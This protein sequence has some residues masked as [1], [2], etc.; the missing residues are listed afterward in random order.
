MKQIGR[1]FMKATYGDQLSESRK[2]WGYR[3]RRL[4]CPFPLAFH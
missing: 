2:T 3:S 4:S 1:D